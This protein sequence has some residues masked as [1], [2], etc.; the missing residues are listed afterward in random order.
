[1]NTIDLLAAQHSQALVDRGLDIDRVAHHE[2]AEIAAL[3][4]A[5]TP[6][7][8]RPATT[9]VRGD[10]WRVGAVMAEDSLGARGKPLFFK[11][12]GPA[13][14]QHLGSLG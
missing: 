3:E 5:T 10:R 9:R 4:A 12:R 7:A 2:E 14:N 6:V 13:P 1:M 8:A 11:A